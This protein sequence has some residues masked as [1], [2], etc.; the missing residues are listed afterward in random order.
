MGGANFISSSKL[1][2][3]IQSC[4]HQI[5]L[6]V[7]LQSLLTFIGYVCKHQMIDYKMIYRIMYYD[8][9]YTSFT[10]FQVLI[11]YK[12]HEML[13]QNNSVPYRSR[14]KV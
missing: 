12:L 7:P 3:E 10:L 14:F 5:L 9:L 8:M 11:L 6:H 1:Y 4:L 13:V 2:Y